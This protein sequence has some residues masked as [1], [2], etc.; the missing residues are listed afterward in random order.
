MA[1][2]RGFDYEK[3]RACNKHGSREQAQQRHLYHTNQNDTPTGGRGEKQSHRSG[4]PCRASRIFQRRG[5]P[6]HDCGSPRRGRPLFLKIPDGE[7]ARRVHGQD[8]GRVRLSD[9]GI[10]DVHG[11]NG[12]KGCRP[13]ADLGCGEA[14]A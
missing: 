1:D 7:Y 8:H 2:Q 12:Q 9:G 14:F 11:G 6:A 4:H 5:Q 13:Q 10:V 3:G